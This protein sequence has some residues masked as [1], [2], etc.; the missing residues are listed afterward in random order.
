MKNNYYDDKLNAQKLSMVYETSIPRVKQY[1]D[2]EIDYVR[3]SLKGTEN[4]LELGAGY[5][6][7]IKELAPNCASITGIDISK[8]NVALGNKYLKDITNAKMM[9]MDVHNLTFKNSFDVII[10]LQNGLSAMKI[11]FDTIKNIMDLVSLGGKAF[12]SS[13][14]EKFWDIRLQWFHEQSSKGLLGEIDIEKTKDGIIIC[15]DGFKAT[16][17]SPKHFEEL[18]NSLGFPFKIEE[19]D[20]SSLFLI[21]DK[22]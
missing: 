9:I 5:G 11:N 12:F 7:I 10:C 16:T 19:I 22:K 15:K 4:I 13:Y 2:A 18:G 14:S 21:I 8:D 1:L 20:E 3:K 6:R 17:N